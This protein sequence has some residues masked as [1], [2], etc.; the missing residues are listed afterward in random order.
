MIKIEDC[1][2][3]VDNDL[4]YRIIGC[5][6]EAFKTVGPGFR[7]I[8]YHKIFHQN[9]LKSGFSAKYKE[10]FELDYHGNKV[11]EFEVDEIVEDKVVL[12]LKS[13]QTEFL[14]GNYA[15][16]LNYMQI[17]NIN[18][19]LLINFGVHK[20][21]VKRVIYESQRIPNAENWDKRFFD[22]LP[23]MLIQ[24]IIASLK[25]ID[26]EIQPGYPKEVYQNAL[27]I[28][29]QQRNIF[30]NDEIAFE[31]DIDNIKFTK[32]Q[33]DFWEIEKHFLLGVLAG[34]EKPRIYELARMRN[35]LIKL[36]LTHGI[37]AYWSNKNFQLH[38]IF[39]T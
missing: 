17:S 27:K 6:F 1:P 33:I 23:N 15:Q 9:L 31:L 28:E 11:A 30:Y 12:E 2:E 37:I 39:V 4:N 38:G 29:F 35:Y 7:E 8:I 16:I 13:I 26:N 32:I 3:Y 5:A 24:N 22:D 36:N 34:N 14:P 10:V 21:I 18:I 20:A 19:G 25:K